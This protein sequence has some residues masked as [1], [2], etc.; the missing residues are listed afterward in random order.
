MK[1]L[2]PF[3]KLNESVWAEIQPYMKDKPY[4]SISDTEYDD[5]RYEFDKIKGREEITNNDLRK[6]K[7]ILNRYLRKSDTGF[8]VTSA[9]QRLP[10]AV[11]FYF[12]TGYFQG[13]SDCSVHQ[14]GD[15][16]FII[17]INVPTATPESIRTRFIAQE[18]LFY[19][20]DGWDGFEEW[21]EKT[22]PF[23]QDLDLYKLLK[24][25]IHKFEDNEYKPISEV[26]YNDMMA[27][28]PHIRDWRTKM[29]YFFKEGE[30]FATINKA[31]F[32]PFLAQK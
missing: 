32:S 27:D 18:Q 19:V 4:E 23:D 29:F 31:T 5:L 13:Q 25:P 9:N 24:Q 17:E 3:G 14:Y 12:N 6:I 28:Y 21:A 8:Y 2:K 10:H 16:Y 26:L 30:H 7:E 20:I 22:T 11:D 1:Y 15:E